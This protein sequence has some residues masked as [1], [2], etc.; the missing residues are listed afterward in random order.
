MTLVDLM[1]PAE[2][3]SWLREQP[4]EV[5]VALAA[6]A[7]LR[8]LPVVVGGG[9]GPLAG[10]ALSALFRALAVSWAAAKFPEL[11]T[12]LRLA[13]YSAA[14]AVS[15]PPAGSVT[16]DDVHAV[17]KIAAAHAAASAAKAAAAS[18]PLMP[19]RELHPRA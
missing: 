4:L 12:E 15:H 10:E 2:A 19:P 7:A 13:A 5:S 11:A 1:N 14:D 16:P 17:R 3:D 18:A 9:G 8:T 6:R